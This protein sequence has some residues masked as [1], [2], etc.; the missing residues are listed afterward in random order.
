M[1]I[2]PMLAT[3]LLA[4]AGCC[5][6]SR[7]TQT[8]DS[9][10]CATVPECRMEYE[11][12]ATR[13]ADREA[14][15]HSRLV[16]RDAKIERLS[17]AHARAG[18]STEEEL[19]SPPPETTTAHRR[20]L[21]ANDPSGVPT[22]IPTPLTPVPTP[23]TPFPSTA[24]P[25]S[26]PSASPVPTTEG[27]TTHSQL[28][29]AVADAANAVVVIEA[30]VLFPSRAPI[31]V[32]SGRS[33]SIVGRSA[34][35]GGRVTL[36]GYGW[37]RH[38]YVIGGTLHL[39]SLNLVNGT[40]EQASNNCRPDL[41]KCTG[42]SLLVEDSG[43]LVVWSC[44]IV[45]GGPGVDPVFGNA[46]MGAGVMVAGVASTADLWNCTL[47]KWRASYAPALYAWSPDDVE[48]AAPAMAR[49]FGCRI[50]ESYAVLTGIV[51]IG[52]SNVFG[53]F[54]DCVFENNLRGPALFLWDAAVPTTIERVQV[55]RCIFRDNL[56]TDYSWPDN[57]AAGLV[58]GNG[59]LTVVKDSTFERNYG[60][61]GIQ[62]GGALAVISGATVVLVNVI[63]L[64]NWASYAGAI[65][66]LS[67]GV[68]TAI[69]VLAL[70]NTVTGEGANSYVGAGTMTLYNS[71]FAEWT[72]NAAGLDLWSEECVFSAY[73]TI[74][75]DGTV[76][77]HSA[78]VL[79]YGAQDAS[80]TDCAFINNQVLAGNAGAVMTEVAGSTHFLRATFQGNKA[81]GSG[82]CLHLQG[83]G[84]VTIKDSDFTSCEAMD[85]GAVSIT[86]SSEVSI[87]N[88][89]FAINTALGNGN[90]AY[91]L[92]GTLRMS[93]TTITSHSS[94]SPY[95]I[96]DATGRDFSVQLD[97]V[98]VDATFS[99]FSSSLL[100][101]QNCEG[102]TAQKNASIAACTATS[103]YC[104]PNLCVDQDVG[105][106]CIC[107][108]DGEV[109]D[110]PSDC[111]QSAVIA[112]PVPSLRTLTY[113]V[114][115]PR[116]NTNEFVL[117]NV[118]ACVQAC[119]QRPEFCAR[120]CVCTS[121]LFDLIA[122]CLVI[123]ADRRVEDVVDVPKQQQ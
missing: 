32:E 5:G 43:S 119:V 91:V 3:F 36:D 8:T 103:E 70:R 59:G 7:T 89:R 23:L 113:L 105:N 65:S 47:T 44:D 66:V 92:D 40:A 46:F 121:Y 29:N 74:F 76:Q 106:K 75:R 55:T 18:G 87:S 114:P 86:G 83:A 2:F 117:A 81:S 99:A 104:I 35:D 112:V 4:T 84:S 15:F 73:N 1:R 17:S 109:T 98:A 88:S 27:V 12:L 58:V 95:S 11:R 68:L 54:E 19:A 110:F 21:A 50:A 115:K 94:G 63:F 52:W 62:H 102:V 34:I 53:V 120:V 49:L 123:T 16:D 96:V 13:W 24:M 61:N 28:T 72:G 48:G 56:G 78:A 118:S 30:P 6:A 10:V 108:V 93:E 9:L 111:M 14:E 64:D 57:T 122:R 82:G 22:P 31:M 25:S 79:N 77:Q 51:L 42:G 37:S 107:T 101:I 20:R 26:A 90:V 80:F 97:T 116:N 38:F 100:L 41:W 85:G 39:S 67:G 33:V 60:L 71:T 69:N 45:G